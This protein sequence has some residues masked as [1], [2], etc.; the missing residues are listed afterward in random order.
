MKEAGGRENRAEAVPWNQEEHFRELLDLLPVAVCT[1]SAPAGEITFYNRQAVALWGR[2]PKP[3]DTEETWCGA[4]KSWMPDGSALPRERTPVA[5]ALADGNSFRNLRA[6]IERPPPDDARV[7]ALVNIDPLRDSSGRVLGA[8]I[9]FRELAA[10]YDDE[11]ALREADRRFRTMADNSPVLIWQTDA[12]GVTFVNRHYLSFFGQPFE[13][14]A[15]MGWA[16]LLHPEDMGYL[17]AYRAAFSRRERC[18]Y[19]A[20]FRRH[21]GEYRWLHNVGTPHCD[22]HGVF[23]GFIG[24]SFDVSDSKQA[25]DELRESDRK[26]DAFLATLAH[27]LR[28][29]LA[30]IRN[31]LQ[32]MKQACDEAAIA[33]VRD[34]M[35]RQV[36]HMARLIADLMDLSRIKRGKILLQRGRVDLADA[37]RDAIEAARPLLEERGHELQLDLPPRPLW[38]HADRARLAQVFGNIL[39]NAVRYTA[40]GG[41]VALAIAQRGGEALVSIED[42]G[43]GIPAQLLDGVFEMFSQIDSSLE[44]GEG[45][46]GIGLYLVKRL[47]QLHGGTIAAESHG[48]GRGSRFVVRLPLAAVRTGGPMQRAAQDT[49]APAL[50][51]R[52]LVVD[53]NRDAADSLATWLEMTGNDTLAVYDGFQALEIGAVF[54]PDVLLL[55]VGMPRLNGFDT[56]RRIRRKSWGGDCVIVACTGWGQ[57][58]DRLLSKAAGFDFHRV[59]PVDPTELQ[60]LLASLPARRA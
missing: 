30:P 1:V 25:A 52:I 44:K 2:E 22:P 11:R 3:G 42:N 15:G 55:D 20:R 23:V 33:R 7:T 38:L 24:C 46:L 53:D 39:D 13:A 60:A 14:L 37:V 16:K 35:E 56:C 28:N 18:D 43:I 17:S 47:V 4:L 45:G 58:H 48:P 5:Q 40:M 21:D 26:K 27:E 34:M 9:V 29:P 50:R 36:V 32:I 49:P 59:K 51:R 41:R 10:E 8:L 12:H 19:H 54:K 57:E 31:G 6:V